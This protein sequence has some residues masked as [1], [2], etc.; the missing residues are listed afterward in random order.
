MAQKCKTGGSTVIYPRK[1]LIK[2]DGKNYFSW[3]EQVDANLTSHNLKQFLVNHAI[4]NRYANESDRAGGIVTKE[5][6][7][8]FLQDQMLVP[9]LMPS[10]SIGIFPSVLHCS[11][12]WEVWERVHQ[13]MGSDLTLVRHI[14]SKLKNTKKKETQS[15]SEYVD[16]IRYVVDCLAEMGESVCEQ[17]HI[18]A[19]LEG[20]P[21]E[22]DAMAKVIRT[23]ENPSIILAESLLLLNE[24]QTQ[25]QK[26]PGRGSSRS[27]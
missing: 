19:I 7:Q 25:K 5:Y 6:K 10:I 2:L 27:L 11:H 21:E 22:Y 20:L 15:I 24:A 18:E 13:H 23:R 3:R 17:E 1:I 12:L 26:I 8:W 9:W 16:S 4:P 14:R